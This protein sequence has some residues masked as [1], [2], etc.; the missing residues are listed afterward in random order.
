MS[1]KWRIAVALA[2]IALLLIGGEAWI[3]SLAVDQTLKSVGARLTAA[4][5]LDVQIG[6]D[7]HL[8]IL[9]VLRFE[10]QGVTV[11]DPERPSEPMLQAEVLR[12]K[13]DPWRLLF[14][15]L[16]IEE[17]DFH[18]AVRRWTGQTPLRYRQTHR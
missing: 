17:L 5:G 11:V 10:A 7:F 2:V 16:V 18:R 9:P 14:G 15:A 6:R 3:E 1:R 4:T 8:E 12:L 13:I